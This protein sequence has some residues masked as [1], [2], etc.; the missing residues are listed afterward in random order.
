MNSIQGNATFEDLNEKEKVLNKNLENI[1]DHQSFIK[2][3][4]EAQK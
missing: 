4:E 1:Q 2:F 3:N